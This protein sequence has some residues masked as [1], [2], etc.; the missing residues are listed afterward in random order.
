MHTYTL[1]YPLPK[2]ARGRVR[3]GGILFTKSY[4]LR[5]NL[6]KSDETVGEQSIPY[7][8]QNNIRSNNI[9]AYLRRRIPMDIQYRL[10]LRGALQVEVR[11]FRNA[12]S[13]L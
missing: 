5:S 3:G 6:G 9:M 10:F 1:L 4:T 13:S 12:R 2:S 11:A 8:P 7:L